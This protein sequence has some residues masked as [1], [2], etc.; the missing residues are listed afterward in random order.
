MKDLETRISVFISVLKTNFP[1]QILI[2]VVYCDYK[3]LRNEIFG[4][5]PDEQSSKFDISNIEFKQFSSIFF[6]IF[7]KH[8]SKKCKDVRANQGTLASKTLSLP[9]VKKITITF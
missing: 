9:I 6:E 1:K 4:A 2:K 8:K 5:E 3:N 7:H